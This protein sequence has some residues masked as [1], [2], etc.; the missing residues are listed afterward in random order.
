MTTT[1]TPSIDKTTV[2][3]A[4]TIIAAGIPVKAGTPTTAKTTATVKYMALSTN[5][6][7]FLPVGWQTFIDE[8]NL[9]KVLLKPF[10]NPFERP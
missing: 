6:D 9:P 8:K 5:E 2:A 1:G 4:K 10:S 3:T 7:V